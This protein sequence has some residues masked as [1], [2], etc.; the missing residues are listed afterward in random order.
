MAVANPLRTEICSD[1]VAEDRGRHFTVGGHHAAY[2][3][4]ISALRV[5]SLRTRRQVAQQFFGGLKLRPDFQGVSSR[6]SRLV[7]ATG[8]GQNS[9]SAIRHL[10]VIWEQ[11]LRLCQQ[12]QCFSGSPRLR[13]HHRRLVT[14][15]G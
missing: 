2:Q 4:P 10:W 7:H 11:L 14:E 12:L 3:D 6:G 1:R 8:A 5:A 9:R 13:Q 15:R